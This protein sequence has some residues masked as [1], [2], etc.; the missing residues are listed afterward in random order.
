MEQLNQDNSIKKDSKQPWGIREWRDC[1]WSVL[2]IL[3]IIVLGLFAVNQ[4][5][6]YRYKVV[7]LSTPC[8]LCAKVNPNRGS[9]VQDCFS[10]KSPLEQPGLDLKNINFTFNSTIE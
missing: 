1:F 10:Y 6:E 2:F 9:C 5:L 8:E 7:F 3:G 4:V